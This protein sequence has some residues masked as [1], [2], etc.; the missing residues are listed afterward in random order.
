MRARISLR[1]LVRAAYLGEP[2]TIK[3]CIAENV[4]G[5]IDFNASDD[6]F[7]SNAVSQASLSNHVNVLK[8]LQ[9]VPGVDFNATEQK[10][11]RTGLTLAAMEDRV[12][13]IEFLLGIPGI[14][15]NVADKLGYTALMYAVLRSQLASLKILLAVDSIEVNA[16]D[17]FGRT[18][19]IYAAG[20]QAANAPAIVDELL[21]RSDIDLHIV[22]NERGS[23]LSTAMRAGNYSIAFKLMKAQAT[24]A[25]KGDRFYSQNQNQ[26]FSPI[27][28]EEVIVED[29]AQQLLR[30]KSIF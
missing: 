22:D 12:N 1:E 15:I 18:V 8:V 20:S 6:I 25:I 23:A 24:A 17:Q 2:E 16:I 29:D 27:T 7:R 10:H 26:L 13:S 5:Y 21:K 14:K 11:R 28:L 30:N 9:S 19:L 3:Q 4:D